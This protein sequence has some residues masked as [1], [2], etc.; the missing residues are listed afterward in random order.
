MIEDDITDARYI[1]TV[2][3]E[4]GSI[5]EICR[6]A[7]EGID[8]INHGGFSKIFLD[9]SFPIGNQGVD[10]LLH[11]RQMAFGI[12]VVVVS[13]H[14]SREV[15]QMLE[16]MNYTVIDKLLPAVKFREEILKTIL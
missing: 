9:L 7:D 6:T 10:V 5:A 3:S 8:K 4:D 12:P 16:G 13:G 15:R 14:I 2:L 1:A 11:L